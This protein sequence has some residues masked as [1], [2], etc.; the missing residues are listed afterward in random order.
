MSVSKKILGRDR[1]LIN[2]IKKHFETYGGISVVDFPE[3]EEV[4]KSIGWNEALDIA[5]E[6]LKRKKLTKEEIIEEIQKEYQKNG[7]V[8]HKNFKYGSKAIKLFG[9]WNKIKTQN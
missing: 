2:K 1:Q 8:T 6:E 7:Q 9:S 3:Y 5:M 4:E